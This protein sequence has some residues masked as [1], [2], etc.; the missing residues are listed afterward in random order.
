VRLGHVPVDGLRSA[1]AVVERYARLEAP[2][3]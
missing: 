3:G 1:R 2:R